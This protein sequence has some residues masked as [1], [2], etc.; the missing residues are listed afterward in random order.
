VHYKQG[1][2]DERK[3]K[4]RSI[5]GT[6]RSGGTFSVAFKGCVPEIP[7]CHRIELDSSKLCHDRKFDERYE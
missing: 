1:Q 7:D 5:G 4:R 2:K 3:R 6:A